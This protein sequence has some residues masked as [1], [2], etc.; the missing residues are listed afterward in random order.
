MA[1]LIQG[2]IP[3]KEGMK[4]TESPFRSLRAVTIPEVERAMEA[5]LDVL[6]IYIMN[7]PT[8]KAVA[9]FHTSKAYLACRKAFY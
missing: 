7:K 4:L 3:A 2:Q 1:W 6:I 5:A 8:D 9:F